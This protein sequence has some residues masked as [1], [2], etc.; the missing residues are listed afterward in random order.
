[1]A[2]Y[3]DQNWF[4]RGLE[5]FES[6]GWFPVSSG[7]SSDEKNAW[8]DEAESHLQP[9]IGV[10]RWDGSE[11]S[12]DD[13]RAMLSRAFEEVDEVDAV[14]TFQVWPLIGPVSLMCRV[15]LFTSDSVPDW[16]HSDE[17][18]VRPVESR[19]LGHGIQVTTR[20]PV[21]ADEGPVEFV[22]VDL[23]FNDG[24][25][26]IVLTLEPTFPPM[27]ANTLPGLA[28]LMASISLVRPNGSEF[29]GVAPDWVVGDESWAV[30]AS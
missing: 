1:M 7:M 20:T 30:D 16:R 9:I 18:A 5:R 17:A 28:E 25:G 21:V 24:T 13:L 12:R 27:V 8:L 11:T 2:R 29:S 14:A 3:T 19:R 23:I 26:A 15:M 10:P 22:S 6:P 4:V